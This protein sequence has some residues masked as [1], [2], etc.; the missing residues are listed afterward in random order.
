MFDYRSIKLIK[1][2]KFET[3]LIE[4]KHKKNISNNLSLSDH[5]NFTNS[6]P[7]HS[8]FSR[9]FRT[10]ELYSGSRRTLARNKRLDG[11]GFAPWAIN[12]RINLTHHTF[13]IPEEQDARSGGARCVQ[14]LWQGERPEDRLESAQHDGRAGIDVRLL[15]IDSKIFAD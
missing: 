8:N 14:I 9:D 6:R 11:N 12:L 1:Q 5:K 4:M 13:M 3:I 7:R 10:P 2:K 15:L